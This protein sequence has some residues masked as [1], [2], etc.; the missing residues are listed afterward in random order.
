MRPRFGGFR[1][2]YANNVGFAHFA[3]EPV[4]E[5]TAALFSAP[6]R[7]TARELVKCRVQ[8]LD[9]DA[10][11]PPSEKLVTAGP[12]VRSVRRLVGHRS[13]SAQVLAIQ[14]AVLV[15]TLVAG[16]L[17][18]V[19][20]QEGQLDRQYEQRALGVAET[21][22]STASFE[23]AV[24]AGDPHG[25]VQT[26]AKEI[27]V[28]TGV[29]YVV[30]TNSHGIRYSHPNPALIGKPVYDD[31]EPA[32]SEPYRTGRPWV[33]MQTGTLGLTA[34][35]KAPIFGPG[36]R[37]VG[38]VSVGIPVAQVRDYLASEIPS[39]AAYMLAALGPRDR[40]VATPD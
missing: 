24:A 40:P 37:L 27:W 18:A 39:I 7:G 25:V 34:R 9:G 31:P 10:R 23:R 14:T 35:G 38:E 5:Q 26:M 21:V 16:F 1:N 32:S 29:S 22:A 4:R 20:Y 15:L 17:L 6:L 11:S 36:H 19:W 33:G 3:Q 12:G 28:A 8:Q 30:V 13:L 2:G